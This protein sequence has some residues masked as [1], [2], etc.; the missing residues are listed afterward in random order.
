[1]TVNTVSSAGSSAGVAGMQRPPEPPKEITKSGLAEMKKRIEAS[2]GQVP[3]GLDKL[4]ANFD[5]AAGD[6]GKMTFKEFKAYAAENGVTIQEPPKGG[7]AGGKPPAGGPPPSGAA[8]SGRSS[9]STSSSSSTSSS[10]GVTSLSDAELMA[11]AAKGNTQ[12]IQELAKRQAAKL[13][14]GD[15]GQNVDT[16]A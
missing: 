10:D 4:I 11:L 5:E 16:F 15:I 7:A 13:D 9:R 1:M 6:D 8:G 3:E 2:G 12:A 14:N